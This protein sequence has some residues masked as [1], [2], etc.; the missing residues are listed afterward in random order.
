MTY[1]KTF[2][3]LIVS[4]EADIV[5]F[6]HTTGISNVILKLSSIDSIE[7]TDLGTSVQPLL[8]ANGAH[9]QLWICPPLLTREHYLELLTDL[10]TALKQSRTLWKRF[11]LSL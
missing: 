2:G 4:I 9:K 11:L 7:H 10:E 5:K 1:N 8:R 3:D 6:T